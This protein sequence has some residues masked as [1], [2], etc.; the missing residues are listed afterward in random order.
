MKGDRLSV[1]LN[2][3]E[4]ISDAQLPDV[5]KTGPIALQHHGTRV[6]FCNIYL[7]ELK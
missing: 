5:R 2:G 1:V 4:V 6:D 7:K 3:E